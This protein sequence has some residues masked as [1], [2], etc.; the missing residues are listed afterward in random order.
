MNASFYNGV[1][2]MKTSQIGIDVWGD[3]IA[4]ANT[5]AFKQQ[6]VDFSSLFT[7]S[8]CNFGGNSIVSSDIGVGS[9]TATT[10]MDLSQGDIVATDSV[11]DL[12][13]NGNGWIAINDQNNQIKYTRTGSFT[14]DI[15]G[16]LVNQHGEKLMVVNANNLTQKD[17]EWKFDNSIDTT[18]LISPTG[19]IKLSSINLPNNVT[20]PAIATKNISI[21]GNLPNKNIAPHTIVANKDNDFG[22]LYNENQESI[23]L[24]DSQSFVFGFGDDISYSDGLIREVTCFTDDKVDGKDVNIDFDINGINIK[25]TIPDGSSAQ[26]IV[27]AISNKIDEYNNSHNNQILYSKTDNYLELKDENQI[28]LKNSGD[29][30]NNASMAKLTYKNQAT[31]PNEF[32][33]IQNLNDEI[34]SLADN[35]YTNIKTGLDNDGKLYIQNNNDSFDV[36]A[37][38]YATDK[39]NNLFMNNLNSLGNVIKPNT[40]STSLAFRQNYQ[41]FTGDIIDANGDKNDLKFH[42]TKTKIDGDNTIWRLNLEETDKDGKVLSTY[43]QKLRFDSK[44]GL[45]SPNSITIDNN[46]IETTI[47]LGQN[48]SGITALDKDNVSFAYSQDGVE[49][50]YLDSYDIQDN[51]NIIATFSNSKTGVLAQIPIYHFQNEHGL[52]SLGEGA[53]SETDNSGKAFLYRNP[54]DGKYLNKAFIKNYSLESSNVNM[55]KAMTQLII[56]QKAYDANSKSITTSDQFLKKAIDMKR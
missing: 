49:T 43:N 54:N 13:L 24:Q 5:T 19:T 44:G 25:T 12:A 30:F 34:K 9:T 56:I 52:D 7:T 26:D 48:F 39:S 28:I 33:T 46:G 47:N 37:K 11:F 21:A 53:F 17:G 22:V 10:T 36:T 8:I 55:G 41:G 32:T 38:S 6:N 27:D 1:V 31:N 4:N 15:N 42:F 50:G 51:G 23:N 18:N 14:K 2:G 29:Y 3:N 20:F 35:V 45:I 40:S 16:T